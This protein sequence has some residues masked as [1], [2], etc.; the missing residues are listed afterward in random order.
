[1]KVTVGEGLGQKLVTHDFSEGV[2]GEAALRILAE[3]G[4]C[5]LDVEN[6]TYRICGPVEDDDQ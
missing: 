2:P 4:G 5:E 1:M 6:G 3:L